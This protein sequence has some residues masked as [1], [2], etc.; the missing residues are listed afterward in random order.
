LKTKNNYLVPILLA[1]AVSLGLLLGN[2][3]GDRLNVEQ[4]FQNGNGAKYQ[5]LQDILEILDKKYVDTLNAERLFEESIG[6]MLHKL[7]PHSN[8]IP[9]RELKAVKESIEGKFG[10]IGVRFFLLRDTICITHVIPGSPSEKAGILAGDK[11]VKV[12]GKSVASKK[13]N[14]EKIMSL[15]K[16]EENTTV[17]VHI[18]RTGKIF[19]KTIRRGSIP[20]SSISCVDMISNTVG[21]VKIE[22][23]SIETGK[24]FHQAAQYLL[25]RGMRKII[26]DVRNN[27]GGILTSATQIVDE[28]L[29]P[30]VPILM[31]KGEHSGEYTYRAT[32]GG[33]LET[34]KV[35]V[36][37]NAQSA[38]ASEI[39]AGALQDNDRGTIVGRR[40][41]G[42]GLV[43]EDVR[44]RDGS[45]LRLTIARYYTP[46]GRCIQKP[47][48]ES[49]E[50][51][52]QDQYN[53]FD[54]G[55]LYQEDTTLFVDS[56]KYKTPKGKIVYGGGGIMPD[57]FIPFDSSG[58][59]LYYSELRYSAAFQSFAFD[60]VADKRTKWGSASG[61]N[62]AFK[63]S[64][65]LLNR[66]T[67]YAEKNHN[68]HFNPVGF[69]SSKKL[70]SQTLKG[71]IA[72]QLW[73]E[74]GYLEVMNHYDAEVQKALKILMK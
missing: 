20:I 32:S 12:E 50:A 9:A 47:Y 60:Y 58:T 69:K 8:Y 33:L 53:R 6:D 41:F 57:V 68:V 45:N 51:Y 42:K 3:Y 37:I 64:E 73:V 39:L 63:V 34:C 18:L 21:Y 35:V 29:A 11:I 30:N 10:G 62:V 49:I 59:S 25:S 26:L 38:S 54:N 74:Q 24:E 44:L 19:P 7:D 61:Y 56:L 36:I 22:Q 1:I 70:I 5:K 17:Q 23:F 14:T 4:G 66:F 28:F 43:Q 16:G 27:G 15:L 52:Y 2:Y 40:S 65:E 48:T 55:E 46:T 71:E 72:R 13:I 67:A 31:T